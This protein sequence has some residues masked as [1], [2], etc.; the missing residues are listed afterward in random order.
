MSTIA[1]EVPEVKRLSGNRRGRDSDLPALK[2][3]CCPIVIVGE[4]GALDVP[5]G[6]AFRFAACIYSYA[7]P[8]KRQGKE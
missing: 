4:T 5:I 8:L 7:T 6:C 3:H 2:G 1:P